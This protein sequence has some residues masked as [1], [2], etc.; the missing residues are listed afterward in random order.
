MEVVNLC[1]LKKNSR[2]LPRNSS[3]VNGL[4]LHLTG[5]CHKFDFSWTSSNR[6]LINQYF[7]IS[8]RLTWKSSQVS[9]AIKK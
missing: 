5:L 1:L 4:V 8:R 3:R 2:R 9:F 7:V 6:K